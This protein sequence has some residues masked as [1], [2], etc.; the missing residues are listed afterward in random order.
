MKHTI[1][2]L[3]NEPIVVM[4]VLFPMSGVWRSTFVLELF[5]V[6]RMYTQSRILP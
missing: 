5:A 1:F 2:Y 3:C 4:L 6:E